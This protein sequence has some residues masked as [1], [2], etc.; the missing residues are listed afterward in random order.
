MEHVLF[1]TM[2]VVATI[3]VFANIN[4]NNVVSAL[5]GFVDEKNDD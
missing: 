4:D 1:D 2:D 3:E 5:D